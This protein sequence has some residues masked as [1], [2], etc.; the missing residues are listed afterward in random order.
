MQLKCGHLTSPKEIN[1]IESGNKNY[2]KLSK[3]HYDETVNLVVP[4]LQRRKDDQPGEA[5]TLQ[6]ELL[7]S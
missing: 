7:W 4:I 5:D 3:L 1:N 6:R 2:S